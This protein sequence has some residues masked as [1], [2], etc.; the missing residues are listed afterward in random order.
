MRVEPGC[1]D[2]QGKTVVVRLQCRLP[3]GRSPVKRQL[4]LFPCQK[5][6]LNMIYSIGDLELC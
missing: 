5:L 6:F 1:T 3:S 4:Y 2:C